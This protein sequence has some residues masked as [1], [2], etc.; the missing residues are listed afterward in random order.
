MMNEREFES[1]LKVVKAYFP[2]KVFSELSCYFVIFV[3]DVVLMLQASAY[4][5]SF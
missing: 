3:M 5:M 4:V 1:E 2:W